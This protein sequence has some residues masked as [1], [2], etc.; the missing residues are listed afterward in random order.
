MPLTME[1]VGQ[2]ASQM[3][4]A[5]R[6][7]FTSG[8]TIGRLRTNDWVFPQEY[9]SGRHAKIVVNDG[10]Y[11]IE[12]T[13]TNG[14]FINSPDNRL[15]RGQLYKLRDGDTL[16][17]DDFEVRVTLDGDRP[18][19]DR[20]ASG[21]SRAAFRSE[22]AP[23]GRPAAYGGVL[24]QD[25]FADDLGGPDGMDGET[26]P[27]KLLGIQTAKSPPAGPSAASLAGKSPLSQ[28]YRPP[29]ASPPAS[30]V[31]SPPPSPMPPQPS[32]TAGLIPDDYDPFA[33]DEPTPAVRVPQRAP[34]VARAPERAPAPVRAQPPQLSQPSQPPGPSRPRVMPAPNY[35]APAT[36]HTD[37]PF[38]AAPPRVNHSV[39][40][41]EA[42]ASRR[43][44]SATAA[45]AAHAGASVGVGV[46]ASAGAGAGDLDFAA[47]LAAA[48]ID[49]A[50]ITPEV[51]RQFG[52]I[53]RVVVAGLMD[54][55]R[56]RE[57]IKDEFRMRATNFKA[58]D[59]NPLK[60][61]AN[62]EDALHN[63][64][65][66]RNPAYLGPVEAFE[67]AFEDLRNHQMAILA[68]MRVAY[69]AMLA[70]FN[71]DSLQE[72]FDRQ[73]KSGS[74]LSAL[75]KQRYWDLYRGRFHD[76]VKDEDTSFRRL[77]GEE[78]A[79]AYEDQLLRLRAVK[80]ASRK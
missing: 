42:T 1:V 25:P 30:R 57:K 73:G 47:L 54:V 76:M 18:G 53:L 9:I 79:K 32:K 39:A 27:L 63:L 49:A 16:F 38:S 68:G 11:F 19:V 12:D 46:G 58:T 80:P 4:G 21:A 61:S 35:D 36:A 56:A 48:G 17:I 7:V 14:V 75:A 65:M 60:F 72:E 23:Y 74:F 41:A 78:F 26:D 45:A 28:H 29:A 59:N 22:P 50:R 31:E 24:P 13:S 55:L 34:L 77:F 10:S 43:A 44:I 20:G 71:P 62:V 66:K 8:G 2:K 64:L 3:G 69:E 40:S 15:N 6:K 37:D 5:V 33:P 51:S 52:Q 70:E 67:D